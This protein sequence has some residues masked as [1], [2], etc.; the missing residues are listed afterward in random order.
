MRKAS[1][2][3]KT[4]N[5]FVISPSIIA[6]VNAAIERQVVLGPASSNRILLA[7]TRAQT[8]LYR[9]LGRLR[10]IPYAI[11][12]NLKADGHGVLAGIVNKVVSGTRTS[13]VTK[14][15]VGPLSDALFGVPDGWKR[16]TK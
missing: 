4:F 11:D 15:A 5:A 13:S 14:V 3:F 9:T 1:G 16:Q 10:G 8:E 2:T 7:I 6:F 12:M